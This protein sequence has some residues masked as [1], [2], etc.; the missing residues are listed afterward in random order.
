MKRTSTY[1]DG[2]APINLTHAL[3]I[4]TLLID[5][6]RNLI[7]VT[8]R[9]HNLA[10]QQKAHIRELQE[11][12]A[13]AGAT[14]PEDTIASKITAFHNAT[15]YLPN[16]SAKNHENRIANDFSLEIDRFTDILHDNTG[17][18]WIDRSE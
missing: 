7:R 12:A 6:A 9:L 1:K 13:D 5:G 10:L 8:N 16:P 17:Y 2:H 15:M 11:F 4:I 14:H 18:K 3:C